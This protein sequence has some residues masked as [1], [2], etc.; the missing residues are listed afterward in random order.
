[1]RVRDLI[2]EGPHH[3]VDVVVGRGLRR[4]FAFCVRRAR[5][6]RSR[7]RE[8]WA[9]AEGKFCIHG[10]ARLSGEKRALLRQVRENVHR[11]K[12][13]SFRRRCSAVWYFAKRNG[14]TSVS[15]LD[16]FSYSR[17]DEWRN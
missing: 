13:G 7:R 9:A 11:L 2:A 4:C 6:S 14:K 12:G 5:P 16:H 10:F 1:M 8:S 17:E 3:D 15:L